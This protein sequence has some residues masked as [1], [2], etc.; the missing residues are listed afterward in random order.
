MSKALVK[1][2]SSEKQVKDAARKEKL[3]EIEEKDDLKKIMSLPEGKRF[4]WRML[5]HCGVF[6]SSVEH[7]GSMTYFNEGRRDVGLYL[8]NELHAADSM[9]LS[10]LMQE[11]KK[12]NEDE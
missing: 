10:K 5:S 7:S 6:R 9:A 12:E 8:I 3:R 2:T 1:N 4:L 11:H